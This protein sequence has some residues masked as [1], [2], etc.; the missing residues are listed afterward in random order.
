MQAAFQGLVD[1]EIDCVFPVH[2]S[3]YDAEQMN[4]ATT[5]PFLQTEMYL[6]TSKSS[7]KVISADNEVVVAVNGTNANYKTFLMDNF[8]KWRIVD[9]TSIADAINTVEASKADC[10]LVNNYQVPKITAENYDLYALST[11]KTM[12]F[13]FAVRK[14]DP[15]LYYTLNKVS[16]LV[17]TATLNAALTSYSSAG[18]NVSLGEFLRMHIYLITFGGLFVAI[19]IVLFIIR[20]AKQ[21]EKMLKEKLEIQAKQIENKNKS[22]EIEKMI[23]A[24]AAD[25]RSV[26]Y[27]DLKHDEGTCYP[28]KMAI[29][30]V[31]VNWTA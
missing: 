19:L 16:S 3:A 7:Q 31:K 4:I 20:R 23:T 8:P 25:Y 17:P 26:Y 29:A 18:I 27:V 30:F 6:M 9:C 28:P 22:N 15:A 11:G 10:A 14:S 12:N 13:S 24:I 1:N 5:T 2:L 21:N